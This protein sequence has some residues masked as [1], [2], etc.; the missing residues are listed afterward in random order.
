MRLLNKEEESEE[1]E[2]EIEEVREEKD[3]VCVVLEFFSLFVLTGER[4]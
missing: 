3:L 4:F 1:R 2:E